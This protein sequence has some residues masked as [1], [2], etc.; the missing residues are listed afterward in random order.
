MQNAPKEKLF[1]PTT[2]GKNLL[3]RIALPFLAPRIPADFFCAYEG[4][5]LKE[6]EIF[7]SVI[8]RNHISGAAV[9]LKDGADE[10]YCFSSAVHTD[11]FPDNTTYF[12]VASI[13]KMATALIAA[14]LADK[15]ILDPDAP[16]SG[17]LPDGSGVPEVDG[18][19]IRHL[20]SHTS[21]LGDPPELEKMLLENRPW[22]DAVAGRSLHRPGAVFRYSNLGFGLLGCVYEAVT[23]M[24]LEE[25]YQ[26]FL[27]RPL[28]MNATM[29][30]SL[31]DPHKI[32]PVVR[33]LPYRPGSAVAVTK[34][35]SM[36]PGGPD[37]SVHYGYSAGSMYT[38]LP[39]L[40]KLMICIRDDCR[41]LVS[42]KYGSFLKTKTGG[43]GKTSPT[44][45]YGSG[46]LIIRDRRI[47]DSCI[48]GHQGFAYGCVDGAFWEDSTGRIMISLNGGCS[49]AR[50]GR[51]GI[52]NFDL[53]RWAF[54]KEMPGWKS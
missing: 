16:L 47:S 18:V 20:L 21:G 43:Y 36:P 46:M 29:I 34:L 1:M 6:P 11:I 41:P 26:Q 8:R 32:M 13:T 51:L 7:R 30:G 44:L 2:T 49:E 23:G 52:A 19:L 3:Y 35:G 28:G 27:F 10:S 42:G 15:G 22:R 33:I 38:D 40:K 5:T 48:F 9:C 17:F 39:S 14:I 4:R 24:P 54:R 25:I 37:P 53:C 31:L 12:R 50:T 45:S